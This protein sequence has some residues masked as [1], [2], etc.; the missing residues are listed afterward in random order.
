MLYSGVLLAGAPG[1][2]RPACWVHVMDNYA[3]RLGTELGNRMEPDLPACWSGA[4]ISS[5]SAQWEYGGAML[6]ADLP[7]NKAMAPGL[8]SAVWSPWQAGEAKPDGIT[9]QPRNR[10]RWLTGQVSGL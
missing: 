4:G 10:V 8:V 3:A 2:N 9:R 7:T 5:Y 1:G 6:W